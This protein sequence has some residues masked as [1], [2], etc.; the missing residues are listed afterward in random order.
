ML[1]ARGHAIEVRILAEDGDLRPSPGRITGW[2]PPPGARVDSGYAAGCSVPPF[3]DSMI[4]KLIVHGETRA[5][6]V[7]GLQAALAG[8]G[9]AGIATSIP[10]LARIVADDDFA[11]N[12]LSTRW[13]ERRFAIG[14]AA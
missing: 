8:F 1:V 5:D 3:Y 13:L 12:R 9:V 6:A 14:A 7:A 11:A 4:A 10:W 2:S